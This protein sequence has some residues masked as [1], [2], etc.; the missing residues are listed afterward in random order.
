MVVATAT[1]HDLTPLVLLPGIAAALAATLVVLVVRI[2]SAVAVQASQISAT[3]DVPGGPG[4]QLLAVV[5]AVTVA[6]IALPL[7]DP[8]PG[9]VT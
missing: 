7:I 2:V 5:L 9:A 8:E 3:F 1:R 4:Q 6:A